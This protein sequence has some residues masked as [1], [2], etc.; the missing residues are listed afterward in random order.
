MMTAQPSECGRFVR[1][2]GLYLDRR[3]YEAT[4]RWSQEQ[5]LQFQDAIQLALC[6]FN[7]RQEV[8]VLLLQDSASANSR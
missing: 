4:S 3:V 8:R 1:L 6:A 2:D 7:E 5:Q